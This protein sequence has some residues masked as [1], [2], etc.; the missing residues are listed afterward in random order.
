MIPQ[1]IGREDFGSRYVPVKYVKYDKFDDV[2]IKDSCFMLTT[3]YDGDV[4]FKVGENIVEAI[5]PSLICFDETCS[6]E[7]VYNNGAVC[8]TV[9]FHPAFLSKSLTFSIL[10]SD[11]Y[12]ELA[13]K[14]DMFLL[15]PFTDKN[16]YIFNVPCEQFEN[17]K[18]TLD[19]INYALTYQTD[20]YWSCRSRSYFI[21]LLLFLER[22][23]G[24]NTQDDYASQRILRDPLVKKAVIYIESNYRDGITLENIA[25][26]ASVNH[27]TL[28][29]LFKCEL[30]MTPVEYLWHHRL[31]VAKKFL[32]FTNIPLKEVAVRC[33]FKTTE[34]FNRRFKKMFGTTP[35]TFRAVATEKRVTALNIPSTIG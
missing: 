9:Y 15:K 34:H 4:C 30:F 2:L 12:A 25:K 32:E 13:L 27:S 23:Y 1:T 5:A 24:L 10:R 7:V 18:R 29:K 28:T 22:L 8:D 35:G 17:V 19:G 20:W 26:S 6:P 11:S 31:K 3:V 14:H 16:R 21:E 33:G